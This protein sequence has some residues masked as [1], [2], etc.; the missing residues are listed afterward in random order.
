MWAMDQFN[1]SLI[2]EGNE[3]KIF[4]PACKNSWVVQLQSKWSN[5]SLEFSIDTDVQQAKGI[6][7]CIRQM[8]IKWN[9]NNEGFKNNTIYTNKWM[10]ERTQ[11]WNYF[12]LFLKGP[13]QELSLLPCYTAVN[14]TGEYF[15]VVMASEFGCFLFFNPVAHCSWW[16]R[17]VL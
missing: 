17:W 10:D 8:N 7:A 2:A 4:K 14:D 3:A 15:T 9:K 16:N 13:K 12:V 11:F 1:S 5:L 6:K